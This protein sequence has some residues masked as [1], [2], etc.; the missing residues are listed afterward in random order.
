MNLEFAWISYL[1]MMV[2]GIMYVHTFHL[3]CAV[4]VNTKTYA[5]IPKRHAG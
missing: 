3:S 2:R 5:E 1:S 4:G